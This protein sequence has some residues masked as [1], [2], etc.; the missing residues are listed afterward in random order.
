M[1]LIGYIILMFL[2]SGV[3][4]IE[5]SMIT[6]EHDSVGFA[7]NGFASVDAAD[8]H[9]YDTQGNDL[10]IRNTG[11]GQT[12]GNS[13]LVFGDDTSALEMRFDSVFNYLKL[14]FGNDDPIH[15]DSNDLALLTFFYGSTQ[16][17]Q[18]S[19]LT[20]HNDLMDQM[21]S[22]SG[23]DFNRAIFQY[24]DENKNPLSVIEIVD[25]I[26]YGVTPVPL[27]ASIWLMLSGLGVMLAPG[28]SR[29]RSTWAG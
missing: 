24:T 15:L 10:E 14:S 28:V 19:L 23:V 13:L 20:N 2:I 26:E 16:V 4:S 25:N 8:I 17:A 22:F 21:I 18:T 1:K 27:P 9:F 3:N 11:D 5:A 6:F 7:P 12:N 29:F